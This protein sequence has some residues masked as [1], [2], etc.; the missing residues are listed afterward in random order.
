MFLIIGS[1]IAGILTVLAPCVLPLL[2]IIIGGSING[3]SDDKKR[4]FI[5]AISLAISLFFF[6]LLLKSSTL[7]INIPPQTFSYISGSI[8]IIIGILTLFPSIYAKFISK[9]GV[10]QKAQTALSSGFKSNNKYLGA[11]IIGLALGP[12]FSSCSPVYAY[13][14][15]SIL[16]VSFHYA[17]VLILFYIIGLSLVLLLVGY[18]GNRLVKRMKFAINPKGIFQRTIAILFIIVGVLIITGYDKKFQTWVSAHTPFSIDKVSSK[19]LP[20]AKHEETSGLFNVSPYSAPGFQGENQWINSQKLDI[21]GLKGKVVLVD[22]WTYSC[23]N[24]IRNNPHIESL[25][26]NYKDHGLVVVGVHAPEFSF[27][28]NIANVR[29]GVKQ[30]NITYPVV[31]DNDLK[32]WGAYENRSWPA[33][34]LIDSNGMVRRIHE[35]EGDYDKEEQAVRQLLEESGHD[36]SNVKKAKEVN[37]GGIDINQTPETYLGS[38][39]AS[40]FENKDP[41]AKEKVHTFTPSDNLDYDFWTLGGTWEVD[42]QNIT[43][44]SD[45][46]I[47]RF[48]LSSKEVY[49]VMGAPTDSKVSVLVDNKPI[50]QSDSGSDVKNSSASVNEY[51]LYKL[52]NFPKFTE[53]ATV[54][55]RVPDGVSLNA[56]T[57]G[58]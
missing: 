53:G 57:F 20:N 42:G 30:Q 34:Y 36:L 39:R 25:Y 38:N 28:K 15:A 31:L 44:R 12:V 50:S 47:L 11:I 26:N 40:N 10:E 24:C 5:I 23:I 58:N 49:L 7:L 32:I 8:V 56:F 17:I 13:I 3:N 2:P 55:L 9:I 35:G 19:F 6:T 1:F 54:E 27:E 16:P 14:L 51:R 45:Q 22:F 29:M 52:V 18:Y 33:S 21:D 37:T 43:S 4:P 46:S 41:L 48:R